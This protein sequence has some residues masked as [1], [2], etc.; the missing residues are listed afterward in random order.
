MLTPQE[1]SKHTFPGVRFN[2]YAIPHVDEFL[3]QVTEDYTN[4][5]SENA[6][7]KAKLKTLTDKVDEYRSTEEAMRKALLSAQKM[8]EEMLRDAEQKRDELIRRAEEASEKKVQELCAARK[9]YEDKLSDAKT[10]VA[11]FSR[12]MRE[13]SKEQSAFLDTL[14]AVSYQELPEK[15]PT[16]DD[17]FPVEDLDIPDSFDANVDRFLEQ[18]KRD[19]E[20]E[21][22]MEKAAL[23][24][25]QEQAES[26]PDT[27]ADDAPTADG[28]DDF[29][30]DEK[31]EKKT[32]AF[33]DLQ[34]G[35]NYVVR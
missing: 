1:V 13:L 2:G 30:L 9:H 35:D 31:D 28:E 23:E 32:S 7:L 34:F 15:D 16:E 24:A 25:Q 29:G 5:Y 11:D 4:L 21:L 6:A 17:F 8:S 18:A 3:D 22:A 26:A 20:K 10:A 27:Q 14:E 12:R 19:A 33:D